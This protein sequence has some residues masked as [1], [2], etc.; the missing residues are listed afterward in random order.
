MENSL[1]IFKVR[2][3]GFLQF[4]Y[5]VSS[6]VLTVKPK[7]DSVDKIMTKIDQVHKGVSLHG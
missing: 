1:K 7:S 2:S 6:A 4:A 5:H 3:F